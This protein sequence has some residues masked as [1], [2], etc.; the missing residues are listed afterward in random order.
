MDIKFVDIHSHIQFSEFDAD[1]G[2]VISRMKKG[3]VYS[4]VVGTDLESSALAVSL[5]EKHDNLLA[6][7][8]LHPND[9]ISEDFDEAVYRKLLKSGKTVAVGECGL[10]YYRT[11]KTEENKKR[12]KEIFEKQIELALEFNKPLMI[13]CRDAYDDMLDVLA[14]YK[15]KYSDK[16]RGNIHFFAGSPDVAEKFLKLGFTLSFT[17]V[18]TFA[19]Q[20]DE[21]IKNAPMNMIMT[22]TDCPYVAPSPYRGKRNEPNYVEE[23]VKR[24]AEIKN[25]DLDKVKAA[26]AQ[27][28]I[29]IFGIPAK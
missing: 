9:A 2:E 14:N 16:L 20:Y 10:D 18:I 19:D 4:I 6:S 13:H 26:M 11:E 15:K 25:E 27:N 12:Q 17:G 22:E 24:I 23:V 5:A 29:R 8:G 3:G 21:V 1:R 28:A 7:I